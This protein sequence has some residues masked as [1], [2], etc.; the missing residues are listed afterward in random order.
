MAKI[1]HLMCPYTK[2]FNSERSGDREDHSMAPLRKKKDKR[3]KKKNK[4]KGK[5]E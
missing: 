4:K 1:F 3:E 5:K 2:K